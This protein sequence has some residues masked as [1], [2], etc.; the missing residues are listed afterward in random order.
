MFDTLAS[1]IWAPMS[2]EPAAQPGLAGWVDHDALL[3][4][5]RLDE[6]EIVRLLGAGGFGI[7]YLALDTVLLRHVA[8]KEY[9]PIALAGRGEGAWVS[10]RSPAH[11]QTFVLGL[12]SFFNEARLLAGFDHPALVKVYRFWKANGTAY[13]VMP[14]YPGH[15]LKQVRHVM[16]A[17]PDESWL[18]A[19]VEPL[20]GVLELLHS[21]GVYHRDIAPD[22]ILLQPDGRPVL[23][24]FGAARRAIG[25]RTQTL[26]AVLKPNFAPVE[27]YADVVG[28]RQGPWTDFYALG[29]TMHFML[30]G[31]APTPAVLRAVRDAMPAL[32]AHGGALFPGVASGFLATIDWTLALAP[33]D[34]PQCVASVRQALSG[35]VVPPPPSAR[36]AI[37]PRLP[38]EAAGDDHAGVEVVDFNTSELAVPAGEI[39]PV[40]VRAARPAAS[41]RAGRGRQAVLALTVLGLLGLS[42][43]AL[44][45]STR[46]TS[47]AARASATHESAVAPSAIAAPNAATARSLV[48][49]AIDAV[50]NSRSAAIAAAAK[51]PPSA[52]SPEVTQRQRKAGVSSA[53]ELRAVDA[54][55]R[56]PKAACGDLNFIALAVCV[57]RKCQTRRWQTHPQC[58][59]PRLVEEQR[60]RRID[61][62]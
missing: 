28:M 60:Q 11:A 30:T 40:S 45:L 7:V 15:T 4:G 57:S 31:E 38:H 13:M 47:D 59:E 62:L 37:E 17:P 24:D 56:S 41:A 46:G 42:A 21:E 16:S 49:P 12:E 3:P 20:L 33:G 51:M 27:Q 43:Q 8:I 52:S 35:E 29:A 18:R 5:T 9:M 34:R 50:P 61:Q 1:T 14:Y 44:N 54:G 53:N 36:H 10:M 26:T 25:D 23:L 19:V 48:Q 39:V 2:Q 22:N 58:I 6:F 32:S 55:V